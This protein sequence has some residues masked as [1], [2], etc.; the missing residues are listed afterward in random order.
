M[1]DI[2]RRD[3][4][5]YHQIKLNKTLEQTARDSDDTLVEES[6]GD[7]ETSKKARAQVKRSS[8][9]MQT[10]RARSGVK[11]RDTRGRR[12]GNP[13]VAQTLEKMENRVKDR[14][15]LLQKALLGNGYAF[16]SYV[17]TNETEFVKVT[18]GG[19]AN[20]ALQTNIVDSRVKTLRDWEYEE[21]WKTMLLNEEIEDDV[22]GEWEEDEQNGHV[23]EEQGAVGVS[24][25]SPLNEIKEE[26][27][28]ES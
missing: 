27:Y 10:T 7:K 17:V 20:I 25:K 12:I 6:P 26:E 11:V 16:W 9:V 19:D 13:M 5:V 1:D 15:L 4:E 22:A 24:V 28:G 8:T 18:M 21:Q 14:I 3:K 2:K 23:E